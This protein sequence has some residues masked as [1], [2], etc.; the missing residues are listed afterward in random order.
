VK[1]LEDRRES[2]FTLIEL[3]V[4]IAIIAVLIG[5]LLPAVQK[6][7]EAAA[8]AQQFDHLA[9]VASRVLDA[10]GSEDVN[11]FRV[12]CPPVVYAIDRLQALI[13]TVQ[14]DHALPSAADVAAISDALQVS[15]DRLRQALLDL[16][17]PA[18]YH[19]PGELEAYLE[20]KHS[21]E[22]ALTQIHVLQV[23][24]RHVARIV[25]N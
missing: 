9:P 17:N 23:H 19:V 7:R 25:A 24:V 13:S 20:L 8:K 21:V 1:T 11:C 16:R 3:L 15:E 10:V 2:G 22:T 12:T 18:R 4:V 6:V 14:D 5:L